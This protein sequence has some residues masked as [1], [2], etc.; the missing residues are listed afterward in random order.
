[1][2]KHTLSTGAVAIY[3]ST[4]AVFDLVIVH[5][6]VIQCFYSSFETKLYQS[7]TVRRLVALL[8]D[9]IFTR[10]VHFATWFDEFGHANANNVYFA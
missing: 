6:G 9:I 7:V 3:I 1:M 5:F 4:R 10:I 2:I 8:C